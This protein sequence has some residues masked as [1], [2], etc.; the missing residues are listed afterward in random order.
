LNFPTSRASKS[1]WTNE[2]CDVVLVGKVDIIIRVP[3][4]PAMPCACQ[5]GY[6]DKLT[7][8]KQAGSRTARRR[9]ASDGGDVLNK[10]FV[11][12]RKKK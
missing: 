6:L 10:E 3:I 5:G 9:F 7:M 11:E 2:A 8:Q 1:P 12:R 4:A